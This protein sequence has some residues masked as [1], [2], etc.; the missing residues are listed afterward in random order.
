ML[1][2]KALKIGKYTVV[3][4][5]DHDGYILSINDKSSKHSS[6][7]ECMQKIEKLYD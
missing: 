1:K 7:Y 3:I 4:Y 5:K 2:C 6:Y